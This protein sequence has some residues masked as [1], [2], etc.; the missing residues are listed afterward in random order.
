MRD[1]K[2]WRKTGGTVLQCGPRPIPEN[3]SSKAHCSVELDKI[4]K[5]ALN[6]TLTNGMG[7]I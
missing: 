4:D 3:S 5:F 7:W 6:Y 1:G 2:Q